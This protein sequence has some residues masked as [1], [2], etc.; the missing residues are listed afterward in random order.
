MVAAA[1]DYVVAAGGLETE[2]TYPY[3]SGTTGRDGLAFISGRGSHRSLCYR[4]VQIRHDRRR[5]FHKQLHLCHQAV[6]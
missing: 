4:S 3:T 6:L 1:F 2:K 5:R